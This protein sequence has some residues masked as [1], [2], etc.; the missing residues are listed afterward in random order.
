MLC[1]FS[2]FGFRFGFRI[3]SSREGVFCRYAGRGGV[4]LDEEGGLVQ[5]GVQVVDVGHI[6]WPG[7]ATV[8]SAAVQKILF[9]Q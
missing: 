2:W 4:C 8:R 3:G 7:R 5:V 6:E 1:W 9:G